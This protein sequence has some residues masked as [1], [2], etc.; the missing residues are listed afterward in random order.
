MRFALAGAV[1]GLCFAAD[2]A[3]DYRAPSFSSASLVNTATGQ[4]EFSPYSIC[5]IYGTDLLSNSAVSAT[6]HSEVPDTLAGVTVLIGIVRAG[7]FYVSAN[8]IN[9][10]IPNS[11]TPGTY[12]ITVVRDGIGSQ[13]V[14]LVVQEVSPGL[15]NVAVH[16]DGTPISATSPAVPGEVAIFY[17]TG[18]GRAQP[19]PSDR[20]FARSASPIVHAADFRMLLDGVEIDRSLILYAGLA[21]QSAGLYQVNVRLP[22]NLPPTSPQV[23]VSV[24]GML[25]PPGVR[26]ITG[27]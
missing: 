3:A 2:T 17:G 21:P 15:F 22:D 24:A 18:F 14:P 16:A 26:L 9:L 1:C 10:L 19:D 23:Q 7:L 4:S 20:S 5:T 25:S 12:A 6:G 27:P 13:A 8:Q 11:L